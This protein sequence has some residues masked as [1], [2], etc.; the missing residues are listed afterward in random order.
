MHRTHTVAISA[1]IY[2]E[3]SW[4]TSA[5]SKSHAYLSDDKRTFISFY[6]TAQHHSSNSHFRPFQPRQQPHQHRKKWSLSFKM[7]PTLSLCLLNIIIVVAILFFCVSM[8]SFLSRFVNVKRDVY[9]FN[10]GW[11]LH[12]FPLLCFA[13]EKDCVWIPSSEK[14]EILSG[15]SMGFHSIWFEN[16]VYHT[17]ISGE[18]YVK[19][20]LCSF[21]M[22]R[23]DIHNIGSN[24]L[25]MSTYYVY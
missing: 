4:K 5:D 17:K 25:N 16:V 18:S 15:R 11:F 21:Y 12:F 14:F 22:P 24:A 3:R 23:I 1:S 13:Y 19:S 6:S 7:T 2:K 8:S 9:S 10:N 20:V